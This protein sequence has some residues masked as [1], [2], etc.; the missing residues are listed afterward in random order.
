MLKAEK[1]DQVL[2]R[3]NAVQAELSSGPVGDAFVSLSKEY[4]EI[5]PVARVNGEK[6][7]TAELI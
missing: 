6:P 1:L 5:S 4:A 3:F 7:R 2:N